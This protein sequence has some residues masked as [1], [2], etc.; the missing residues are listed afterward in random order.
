MDRE[1]LEAVYL[2][3]LVA[4]EGLRLP[5]RLRRSRGA[6]RWQRAS[7][8]ARARLRERIVM[9]GLVGGIWLLPL[10]SICSPWLRS[11]DTAWPGWMAWVAVGV[12]VAGFGIRWLGQTALGASWAP[13]P[14]LSEGHQLVTHGI[15]RYIRHPLYVSLVCWA[16]AQPVLLG[17]HLAGWGGPVAVVLVW[18]MRVPAE[19]RMLRDRFGTAWD[20]YAASTGRLW[21]RRRPHHGQA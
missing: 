2:I 16:L 8:T 7:S 18:T 13:T 14:A 1:T 19:E 15:Y 6:T 3:G 4:A 20:A 10:A 5:Q 12:F 11:F 17:N 21:P 9:V